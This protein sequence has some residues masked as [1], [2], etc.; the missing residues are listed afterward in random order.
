MDGNGKI[1]A[2]G[3]ALVGAS[4][5]EGLGV[6]NIGA[7]GDLDVSDAGGQVGRCEENNQ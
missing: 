2:A 7:R 4:V 5:G 1:H 3:D 6:E